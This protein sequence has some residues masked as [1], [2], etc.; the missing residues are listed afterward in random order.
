MALHRAVGIAGGGAQRL[1][2]C[3]FGVRRYQ[4]VGVSQGCYG[5]ITKFFSASTLKMFRKGSFTR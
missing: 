2:T 5:A 3:A 1:E 4:I